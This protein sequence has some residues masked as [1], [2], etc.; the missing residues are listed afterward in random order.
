MKPNDKLPLAVIITAYK[1]EE[2]TINYVKNEL[3]KIQLNHI[4]IIVNNEATHESNLFLCNQLQASIIDDINSPAI[5]NNSIYIINNPINSGFAK[6]NNMGTRFAVKH[7]NPQYI[8]FSN[9]DIKF[10]DNNVVEK[11]IEKI[12]NIHEAG[13][14]GPK[15]IGLKG[16][17]QSP[18][19]FKS[20]KDKHILMPLSKFFCN[21]KNKEKKFKLN[22]SLEAKE[23]FHYKVMGSFFIVKTKDFLECGMMDP[24]TFLYAEEMILTERM[25]S[26]GKKVYYD[27]A[28]CI[29]HEHG[30]TTSKHIKWKKGTDIGFNSECYYYRTY[31]KTPIWEIQIGKLIHFIYKNFKYGKARLFNHCS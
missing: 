23:G 14:I 10:I 8:L 6:G 30:A 2:L 15:V 5:L 19:P 16:E 1:N 20:F 18:E 3:C 9:T 22:Y 17:L 24:Q 28:V 31:I 26:I 27:P 11:L 4:I 7:F 12:K 21:K 29:L 13:I 25:R